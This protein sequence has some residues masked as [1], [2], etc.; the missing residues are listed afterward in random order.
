MLRYVSILPLLL[1]VSAL[2]GPTAVPDSP[3]DEKI[4]KADPVPLLSPEEEAKALKLPPD[5]KVQVV[6]SEPMIEHPV[7]ASFD[8]DGRMWVV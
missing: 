7:A 4:F 1:T 3:A 6:A 8:A 2:A 5:L